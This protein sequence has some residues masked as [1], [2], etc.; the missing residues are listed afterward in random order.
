MQLPITNYSSP[1]HLLAFDLDGTVLS[2]QFVISPRVMA[3][4]QAAKARGV[5]VTIA[6]G[7][8]AAV[9]LPYA[10]LIGVNAPIL[11]LQGGLIYDTAARRAL[12]EL[13][14][15]HGLA[16]ELI[17]VELAH[18]HWQVVAYLHGEMFMSC[19]R[20]ADEFYETLLG[21]D[22]SLHADV[23]GALCGGDPD[24]VLYIIDP[25]DASEILGVLGRLVDGRA[26]VVQSHARFIEV[27]PLGATKGAGLAWLAHSYGIA[28]EH[29]MAIGDQDNDASMIEWAGTGVAMGNGSPTARAVADWIAPDICEDGAAVAI[30]RFVLSA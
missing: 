6:T 5:K 30:E 11:C 21:K 3:A 17:G 18:P 27:N 19:R 28:R 10:E 26:S 8:P 24:K 25:P 22:Y 15:P 29:V 23:C 7:R 16:C 14:L 1:I 13:T 20:H 12:H 4:I 9:T 2:D